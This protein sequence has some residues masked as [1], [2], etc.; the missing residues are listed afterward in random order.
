[1]LKLTASSS[2]AIEKE[3]LFGAAAMSQLGKLEVSAAAH[4]ALSGLAWVTVWLWSTPPR[5]SIV[6]G[7]ALHCV[8]GDSA[9]PAL[10]EEGVSSAKCQ[11]ATERV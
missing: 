7:T 8:G 3:R 2:N 4:S 11:R 9:S 1:M 10:E 5:S 6:C